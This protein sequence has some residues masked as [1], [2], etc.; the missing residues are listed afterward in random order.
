[1]ILPNLELNKHIYFNARQNSSIDL[2]MAAS[3]RAA[4][5]DHNQFSSMSVSNTIEEP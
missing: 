1:M 4:I 5:A 3:N 2:F